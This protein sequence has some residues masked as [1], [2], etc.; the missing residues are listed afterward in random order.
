MTNLKKRHLHGGEL[1]IS[2]RYLSDR[3]W[4]LR[5]ELIKNEALFRTI[6]QAKAQ[7]INAL[8]FQNPVQEWLDRSLAQWK[9]P[10]AEKAYTRTAWHHVGEVRSVLY[11]ADDGSTVLIRWEAVELL[12]HRAETIYWAGN[13]PVTSIP[14]AQWEPGQVLDFIVT[15]VS[16]EASWVPL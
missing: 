16:H 4:M 2:D 9:H 11:R 1:Y 5:R 13:G 14:L 12:G 10:E 3:T 6:E 15:P 8:E 7:G